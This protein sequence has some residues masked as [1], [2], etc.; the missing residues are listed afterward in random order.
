MDNTRSTSVK[1][2][3]GNEDLFSFLHNSP[4]DVPANSEQQEL[5]VY[6][7]DRNDTNALQYWH[8]NRDAFPTLHQLHLKHHS[9][10]ATSAAMERHFNAAGY[11]ISARRNRLADAS[12]ESTLMARCN[13]DLLD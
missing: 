9:M 10:P 3:D 4:V 13:R 7:A 12:I 11:I 5:D 8:A 6:L 2:A 1:A